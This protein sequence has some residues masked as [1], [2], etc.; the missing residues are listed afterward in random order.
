[1]RRGDGAVRGDGVRICRGGDTLAKLRVLFFFFF[2]KKKIS[3]SPAAGFWENACGG[4]DVLVKEGCNAPSLPL[5]A[6]RIKIFPEP[7]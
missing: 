7:R 5:N 3:F 1:M 2:L 6:G 4:G